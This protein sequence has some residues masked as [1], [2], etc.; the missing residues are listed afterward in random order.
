[1]FKK[2]LCFVLAVAMLMSVA[3][4]AA[5]AAQVEIADEAADAVAEV[6]ADA[7][8][9]AATSAGNTL[10]FDPS[11]AGWNNYSWI[12]FHIWSID[13]PNFVGFDW[14]GKKQRGTDEDGDGIWTYDL[15]N[16]GFTIVPGYQY[17]VIFYN[18]NNMQTYNLL[19]GA[20]DR[21]LQR[22]HL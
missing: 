16:A 4:I 8:A 11:G 15:D 10:S 13:D 17:A 3:M 5:S 14:G 7:D 9:D 18:D 2:I 1:M 6:G 19:F 20:E 12:A 22:H 21:F